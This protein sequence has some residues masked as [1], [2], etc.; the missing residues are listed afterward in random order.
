MIA[1]T[2]LYLTLYICTDSSLDKCNTYVIDHWPTADA[3]A[4]VDCRRELPK[5][6]RGAEKLFALE[7][8]EFSNVALACETGA[9]LAAK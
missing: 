8:V 7:S 2:A 1:A 3:A 9:E 5:R 6:R 4:Q